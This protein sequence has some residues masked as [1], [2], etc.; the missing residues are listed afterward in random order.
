MVFAPFAKIAFVALAGI[1]NAIELPPV[2]NWTDGSDAKAVELT[3]S[4]KVPVKANGYP[5]ESVTPTEGC[6]NGCTIPLA[7]VI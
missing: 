4:V 3:D 1:L 6:V 7:P 5:W 2:A